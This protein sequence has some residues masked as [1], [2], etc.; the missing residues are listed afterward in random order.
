MKT[1]RIAGANGEQVFELARNA[2]GTWQVGVQFFEPPSA[3][4]ASI[5]YMLNGETHW[6]SAPLGASIDLTDPSIVYI[7][8]NIRLLRLTISGLVGGATGGFMFAQAGTA[9]GFLPHHF[10]DGLG[11]ESRLQVD[12]GQTGF[13]RG[14]EFRTFRE[15]ETA[16]TG[17]FVVKIVV[18]VNVILMEFLIQGEAGTAR[19]ETVIGGTEGGS[20][21]ETLPVRAANTMTEVPEVYSPQVVMTAGGTLLGGTVIDISRVKMADNSNF[22]ATVGGGTGGAERGVAAGTYYWRLTFA[23]FIGVIKARWEE[24]P[25][26]GT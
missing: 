17:A 8:G 20:F 2:S 13:F 7:Y 18:P 9:M 15:W 24:R 19:V 22:A 10:T 4:A 14:R 11:Q 1:F 21:S 3:G 25:A 6:R 26:G 16:T 23:G 12:V 5:D